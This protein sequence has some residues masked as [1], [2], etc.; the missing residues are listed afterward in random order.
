[1]QEEYNRE[2]GITPKSIVKKIKER[3]SA[4]EEEGKGKG[5]EE[6]RLELE[7]EIIIL[8]EEMKQAAETL[9]FEKAIE[10][11]DRL[12]ELKRMKKGRR[13]KS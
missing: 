7:E 9:E 3:I 4:Y 12:S 1:V 13:K 2:H 5:R 6:E 8:E 10:L 11:R